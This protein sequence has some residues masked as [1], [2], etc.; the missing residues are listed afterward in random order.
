M[1]IKGKL[2]RLLGINITGAV[3]GAV[4]LYFWLQIRTMRG[5][6]PF[7]ILFSILILWLVA[8]VIYWIINGVQQI[9]LHES[10]L[11]LIRGRKK[12]SVKVEYNQITDFYIHKRLSRV[13]LQILLERKVIKIPG[14]LTFYPGKKIWITSDAFDDKEFNEMCK[15]LEEMYNMGKGNQ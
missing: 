13:S 1:I 8:D 7:I 14:I 15:K 2:K 12:N 10:F 6:K 4:I 11:I 9:E 5:L 3:L